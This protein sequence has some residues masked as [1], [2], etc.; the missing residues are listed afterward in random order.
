MQVYSVVCPGSG[1]QF[2]RAVG[3]H[4]TSRF[5]ERPNHT[6]RTGNLGVPTHKR[7]MNQ[8]RFDQCKNI[9]GYFAAFQKV[10]T[11]PVAQ[12]PIDRSQIESII[13]KG[14]GTE[15]MLMLSSPLWSR[16]GIKVTTSCKCTSHAKKMNDRGTDWIEQNTNTVVE[17]LKNEHNHQ[18]I[19]IPFSKT[20]AKMM[21]RVA[22]RR[23]K[24]NGVQ[25]M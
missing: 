1:K 9:P 11:E 16:L 7:M 23:A 20:V 19:K 12:R 8:T 24:K 25:P 14:A 2:S 21:I 5:A 15:L 6:E 17:W 3:N 13:G 22:M 4:T 18:R 10:R